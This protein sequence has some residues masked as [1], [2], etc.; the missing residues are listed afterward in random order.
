MQSQTIVATP[1]AGQSPNQASDKSIKTPQQLE[2]ER[3]ARIEFFKAKHGGQ[4]AQNSLNPPNIEED[5]GHTEAPL[6][7]DL[8]QMDEESGTNYKQIKSTEI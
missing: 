1:A 2:A 8:I 3:K 6:E 5:G 7:G 4:T